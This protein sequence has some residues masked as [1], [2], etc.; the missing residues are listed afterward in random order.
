[1]TIKIATAIKCTNEEK[2]V[3]VKNKYDVFRNNCDEKQF[4][5]NT[6]KLNSAKQTIFLIINKLNA[7]TEFS[8][9]SY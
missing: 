5:I 4:H 7:N 1:M 6:S 9:V 2:E 8:A 3:N